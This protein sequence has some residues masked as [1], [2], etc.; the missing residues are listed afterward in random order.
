M[1]GLGQQVLDAISGT[2]T[3]TAF[4]IEGRTSENAPVWDVWIRYGDDTRDFAE[5]KDTAIEADDRRVFYRRLR[6]EVA[7]GTPAEFIRPVWVT[8]P[9][10]QKPNAL[11]FLEAIPAQA[12]DLDLT[13]VPASC[14]RLVKSGL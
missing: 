6:R 9:E 10:K 2:S 5:C 14:P 3:I 13:S 7:S 8:D 11:R 12:A 1:S 4:S